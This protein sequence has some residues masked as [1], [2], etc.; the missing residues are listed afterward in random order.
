[1][2]V[3]VFWGADGR[4]YAEAETAAEALE[5]IKLGSNG[6]GKHAPNPE[7]QSAGSPSPVK[8]GIPE[9]VKHVLSESS[10]RALAILKVLT[11]HPEG[12]I[13]EVLAEN[14]KQEVTAFGGILGAVTKAAWK[15]DLKPEQFFHSEQKI[16]GSRRYRTYW[17]GKL[18]LEYASAL[19]NPE[20]SGKLEVRKLFADREE[21]ESRSGRMK[22][23][24]GA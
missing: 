14:A 4:P 16:E 15:Y 11:K 9:R 5:L 18:L 2:S 6:F 23:G 22:S 1:M 19:G 20:P 10:E 12:I 3:K 8:E 21:E 17:P 7:A 24:G 13:G